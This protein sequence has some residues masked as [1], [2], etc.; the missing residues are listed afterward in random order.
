MVSLHHSCFSICLSCL[1]PHNFLYWHIRSWVGFPVSIQDRVLLYL[2]V[3]R[4]NRSWQGTDQ[5][6]NGKRPG[7]VLRSSASAQ[8]HY[9]GARG[10]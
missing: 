7:I 2:Q 10:R 1:I 5:G 9:D 8:P 6:A 3:H 4:L